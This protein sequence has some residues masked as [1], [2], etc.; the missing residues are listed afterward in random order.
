M[1]GLQYSSH[2]YLFNNTD[3]NNNNYKQLLYSIYNYIHRFS[4]VETARE[5]SKSADPYSHNKQSTTKNREAPTTTS[6]IRKTEDNRI[7]NKTDN[8][9]DNN[10][11]KNSNSR[12]S[13]SPHSDE[14]RSSSRTGAMG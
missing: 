10:S 2:N 6:T 5:H 12:P 3:N 14:N 7:R 9:S 4:A 13:Q 8:H 1:A 11:Y